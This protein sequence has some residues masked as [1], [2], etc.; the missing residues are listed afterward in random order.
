MIEPTDAHDE[1]R[2]K[3][4]RARLLR[5][6][7]LGYALVLAAILVGGIALYRAQETQVREQ[8][9]AQLLT[10]AE[11]KSSQ[12]TQWRNERLSHA[13]V[14]SSNRIFATAARH[15]L[16]APTP[17]DTDKLNDYFLSLRKYYQY[18]GVLLVDSEGRIRFGLNGKKAALPADVIALIRQSLQ[19]RQPLHGDIH[20]HGNN[21]ATHIDF[22]APLYDHDRPDHPAIGAVVLQADPNAFLYPL[23]QSWPTPS[24][25]SETLLVR[26]DGDE[27]LFIN[28]LRHRKDAALKL[29]RSLNETTLP[30]T[31]AVLGREG[32]FEGLDHRQEPVIA[33]L[34]AVPGVG[35]FIVAKTD[36][37]EALATGKVI[38]KLIAALTLGTMLIATAFCSLLWIS[39]GKRRYQA[40]FEAEAANRELRERFMTVFRA[41]PLASSITR[42]SDGHIID[43]NQ[44]YEEEFGW[45]RDALIGK[46]SVEVGLWVSE[47]ERNDWLRRRAIAGVAHNLPAR[48]VRRSGEIRDVEISAT[49]LSFGQ[50]DHL[51]AFIS[52][53]T[54]RNRSEAEL[55]QHRHHLA[56][57]VEQ[58]T[59]EL[60]QA[61]DEAESASR[62]KSAFLANMSHEIRTPM[63][64]IIGLTHLALRD[65]AVPTQKERLRKIT[66]SAQHLLA[67]INDILDISKIEADK[68][69]LEQNDFETATVFD[70]IATLMNARLAE[71][72]LSMTR[73]IDP[74]LP[75][76]LRGDSLRLSQILVNYVGNAIKFTERGRIAIRAKLIE[77]QD[78]M[79]LLRIEVEDTGTGIAPEVIPRLFSPFEQ[80][81]SST[82]RNF[83]GTG[84]GLAICRRLAR[85][86]GGDVGVDSQLGHGSTFWCTVR[87]A[88]GRHAVR[89]ASTGTQAHAETLL[90]QRT[91]GMCMLIAED[92]LINQEVARGLLEAVGLEVDVADNGEDAVTML[93]NRKYDA[94]LM[95]MQMPVMDG[96]AATQAIRRLPDRQDM[97]IIAMTANAFSD[98]RRRCLEAGMNDHLS[99]PVNPDELFSTLLRWLPERDPGAIA[100]PLSAAVENEP[101][102]QEGLPL[103]VHLRTVPGLDSARG[104]HA[105]RGRES[106]YRMLLATF[107]DTH[108]EDMSR[109]RSHLAQGD[110]TSATRVA[111]SLKGV[112]ATLGLHTIE[113]AARLLETAIGAGT[114]PDKLNPQIVALELQLMD[115]SA[116]LVMAL[117]DSRPPAQVATEVDWLAARAAIDKLMPLLANDDPRALQTLN[118]SNPVLQAALDTHWRD[119]KRQI[120]A[121]DLAGALDTLNA[122]RAEIDNLKEQ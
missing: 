54:E 93:R 121:F 79:L 9:N 59:V 56:E 80:A 30:A 20:E 108:T 42:L 111:H 57:M 53:V 76:V 106:T 82:T 12:I 100:R 48:F 116:A 24:E 41:S 78:A 89:V 84:L 2:D 65:S 109:L 95:D 112:A 98:D 64:A 105:V 117:A 60:A 90:K 17:G 58:R 104:L 11:A 8:F 67:I 33:A 70:N 35:W 21:D 22:I 40:L 32:I 15:Y 75:S 34:K 47:A 87:L 61:K 96:L 13:E 97:P 39:Y 81:D 103:M 69:T 51:I 3:S 1:S 50:E 86:M 74:A 18:S 122:A 4:P 28:E 37:Q 71:K 83:G 91:A 113:S 7:L 77:E 38:A 45:P 101:P 92:N 94:V 10:I 115:T 120:N 43:V 110:T 6:L 119:F 68:I 31:Q 114:A 27:V 25:T 5:R 29:R 52:D 19:S 63:N 46:T 73:E 85:L 102:L 44:R 66:D 16:E 55:D 88:R 62:A 49:I 72:G 107:T 36:R 23:L 118:E 14:L 99:K 26:R